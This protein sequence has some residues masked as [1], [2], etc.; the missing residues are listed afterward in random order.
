MQEKEVY[1]NPGWEVSL[2]A[3]FN[4]GLYI[5]K[6]IYNNSKWEAKKFRNEPDRSKRQVQNGMI[7]TAGAEHQLIFRAPGR[8]P[9]SV[10]DGVASQKGH[11][12]KI[13]AKIWMS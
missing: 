6:N 1:V 9:P 4:A 7:I 5:H 3:H 11:C 8:L 13:C 12:A 10:P 2:R